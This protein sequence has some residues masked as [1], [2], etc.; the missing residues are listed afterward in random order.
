MPIFSDF[1]GVTGAGELER[2][3]DL[4]LA[5]AGRND[6]ESVLDIAGQIFVATPRDTEA[7]ISRDF[8]IEPWKWMDAVADRALRAGNR[9]LPAKIGLVTRIWN[10]VVLELDGRYQGGRLVRTPPSLELHLYKL[11]LSGLVATSLQ[12]TLIPGEQGW[13]ASEALN[14]ISRTVCHLISQGA[15]SDAELRGLATGDPA[16]VSAARGHSEVMAQQ[17]ND[18]MNRLRAFN[19][20]AEQARRTGDA[21]AH[22]YLRGFSLAALGGDQREALRCMEEAARHGHVEA[23]YDA[24]C[25][26]GEM[27]EANLARFWWEAAASAGHG[28]AA[29]NIAVTEFQAGRLDAAGLWFHKAAER[30]VPSGYAGLAQ[31]ANHAG[32]QAAELSWAR[33]GAEA[34]DPFCLTRYGLVTLNLHGDNPQAVRAV[35]P[36]LQRAA[37]QGDRDAMFFAGCG[38]GSLGESYEAR[39]WLLRAEQ[40]GDPRAREA[41]NGFGL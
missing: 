33:A 3:V 30:G 32:D 39:H 14:L 7:Q 6:T 18:R 16:A 15:E 38:H 31:L 1:D 10:H 29:K 2:L 8:L 20:M 28:K 5:Y 19:D 13:S 22:L 11:A 24:G 9:I 27:G 36:Y 41:L 12:G 26:A 25:L 17:D 40:A 21:V 35:L 34:G 23:M 4:F 37:E